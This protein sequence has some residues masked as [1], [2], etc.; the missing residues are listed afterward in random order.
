MTHH[1]R[2]CTQPAL[3]P[4]HPLLLSLAGP[5]KSGCLIAGSSG[6]CSCPGELRITWYRQPE[7]RIPTPSVALPRARPAPLLQAEAAVAAKEREALALRLGIT[8]STAGVWCGR[9]PREQRRGHNC[10]SNSDRAGHSKLTFPSD[11]IPLSDLQQWQ[12]PSPA[13]AWQCRYLSYSEITGNHVYTLPIACRRS[14][15]FLFYVN[16]W[17]ND[18]VAK[19]TERV[20]YSS[21]EPALCYS[22][23]E[24]PI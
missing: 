23:Q 9:R 3:L 6:A 14:F 19:D 12:R 13:L 2:R 7:A 18:T 22:S 1:H 10:C 5:L 20:E 24:W 8:L 17:N 16:C 11:T 15:K 4:P 21:W